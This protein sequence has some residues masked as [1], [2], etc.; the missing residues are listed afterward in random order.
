MAIFED[1]ADLPLSKEQAYEVEIFNRKLQAQPAYIL[2]KGYKKIA[3][4]KVEFQHVL[5]STIG[6]LPEAYIVA[7]ETL[8]SIL[9][10]CL[11]LHFLEDLAVKRTE[12][13]VKP[14]S[15]GIQGFPR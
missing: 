5:S 15:M 10:D 12:Y 14:T 9:A 8:D 1:T 4:H 13:R 3:Y 11:G 7:V 2:P 6:G